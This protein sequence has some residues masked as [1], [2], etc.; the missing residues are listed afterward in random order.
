MDEIVSQIKIVGC[1]VYLAL[2]GDFELSYVQ[3]HFQRAIEVCSQADISKLFF[4]ISKIQGKITTP[5]KVAI[6]YAGVEAYEEHF[7]QYGKTL[8]IAVLGQEQY[9]NRGYAPFTPGV[10]VLRREGVKIIHT[11]KQGEAIAWLTQRTEKE[12]KTFELDT[13]L[14]AEGQEKVE[15]ALHRFLRDPTKDNAMKLSALL[16]IEIAPQAPTQSLFHGLMEFHR[17]PHT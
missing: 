7:R 15:E 12:S 3:S 10:D 5:H 8:W 17:L 1:Y 6:G 14:V 4:D 16:Q 11:H 13:D 9:Y 2:Y